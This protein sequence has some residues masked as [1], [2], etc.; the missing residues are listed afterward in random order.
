MCMYAVE[1]AAKVIK[2]SESIDG[3]FG[4]YAVDTHTHTSSHHGCL[5]YFSLGWRTNVSTEVCSSN[6]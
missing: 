1:N 4:L 2:S 6:N 5:I 3:K